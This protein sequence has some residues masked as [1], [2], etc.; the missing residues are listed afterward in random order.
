M[1]TAKIVGIVLIVISL[2]AGYVGLNRVSDS[3][4]EI[5]FLGLKIDASNE[6]GQMQGFLYLG[7]AAALLAG[8][9]Y[10]LKKSS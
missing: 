7:V 5:N 3:T 8:G 4:K 1:N 9:L 6:S 2:A 10:T